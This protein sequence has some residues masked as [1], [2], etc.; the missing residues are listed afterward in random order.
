MVVCSLVTTGSRAEEEEKE[1]ESETV[2]VEENQEKPGRNRDG[3]K[4]NEKTQLEE[5]E[6]LT[7]S[8]KMSGVVG[9]W[10]GSQVGG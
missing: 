10:V 7:H 1:E 2:G 4:P 9:W 3:W 8:G 6:M 5:G